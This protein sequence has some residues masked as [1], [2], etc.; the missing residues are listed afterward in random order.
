LLPP[1]HVYGEKMSEPFDPAERTAESPKSQKTIPIISRVFRSGIL[2]EMVYRPWEQKTGLIIW[3]GR[4]HRYLQ[5]FDLDPSHRLVPYSAQNNLV[6]NEVVLFPSDAEKYGTEAEL[7]GEI[8]CFIHR[9]I[10][11][12]PLFEKIASYYVLFSWIYDSFNELPYLR[13]RGDYGSGKTRALLTIGSL[14]YKPIFASGASTVSPI[15]R[16][17]DAFRGTLIIDEGDF[18]FSDEKT[19]IVKILNNGNVKGFPVLRSEVSGTKEFNPRAY[20]VF[21]PKLVATRGCFDDRALESRFITEEMG[22]RRLR[23]DIPINL[24]DHFKE[25][26]LHLRNKLLLFRF[27]NFGKRS[28]DEALV[29]R[30]IEPRLNQIFVPLLSIIE[31]GEAREELREIA[32]AYHREIITE[33]GMDTE[34]QVLEVIR[35][36]ASSSDTT[37][38]GVKEIAAWFTDRY[39]GEYERKITNKWI[40]S[41]IRK[42]LHLKTQKSEGVFVIPL[43][44]EQPKLDRLYQ[45]YGLS[46]NKEAIPQD[47]GALAPSDLLSPSPDEVP[48]VPEVP[49]EAENA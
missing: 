37:R 12:S 46:P 13:L 19:E 45:K 18:R 7:L 34:A 41:I 29:D 1:Q 43:L 5:T 2:V 47:A 22:T 27:R 35:D 39:G 33:R 28:T 24:P 36:L 21:G 15:F 38:I 17:L 20:H 48:E 44:E 6:K 42:K 23:E 31:D 14:C 16:I 3:D 4:S 10:D 30:S 25:E 8:Q 49:G 40:G 9:Y 26:A 32:R 11:V